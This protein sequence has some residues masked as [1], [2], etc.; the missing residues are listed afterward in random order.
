MVYIR[1]EGLR[2]T[3]KE[4]SCKSRWNITT[5]NSTEKRKTPDIYV[6]RLFG[7]SRKTGNQR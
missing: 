6:L 1:E 5:M 2:Y 3:G 4:M 7:D